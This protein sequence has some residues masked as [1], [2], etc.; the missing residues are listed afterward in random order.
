MLGVVFYLQI[1]E[2]WIIY[3]I[4]ITQ[5]KN[6]TNTVEVAKKKLWTEKTFRKDL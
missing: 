4:Y 6:Q 3:I 5:K 2:G 1:F